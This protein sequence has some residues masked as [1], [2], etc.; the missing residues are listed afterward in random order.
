MGIIIRLEVGGKE[1]V[2]LSVMDNE[3]HLSEFYIPSYA[4]NYLFPILSSAIRSGVCVSGGPV[5]LSA[6]N[7][8]DE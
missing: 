5:H 6:P 8:A 3:D 1:G 2:Y 4:L 7:E